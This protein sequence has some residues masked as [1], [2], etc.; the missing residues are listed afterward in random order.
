MSDTGKFNNDMASSQMFSQSEGNIVFSSDQDY[1]ILLKSI[2]FQ[3]PCGLV[4][5]NCRQNTFMAND[6]FYKMFNVSLDSSS[7]YN[8]APFH[9]EF[10]KN[11]VADFDSFYNH[12]TR[13]IEKGERV[14]G[15]KTALDSGGT[16]T[17]DIT[18]LTNKHNLCFARIWQYTIAESNASEGNNEL[19]NN[20]YFKALFNNSTDAI[21]FFNSDYKI[22][23]I[24]KNFELLF[25]HTLEKVKGLDVD[26]AMEIGKPG[27]ANYSYTKRVLA[28][29]TVLSEGTRYRKNGEAIEVS[30]KGVPVKTDSGELIGGYAIY[31]DI[32]DQVEAAKTLKYK[33]EFESM[34]TDISS[35]FVNAQPDNFDNTVDYALQKSG[36]FFQVDRSYMFLIS[37][38]RT[39][40]NNTHEWC[41]NGIKPQIHI[42]QNININNF[43][44]LQKKI[45]K[46]WYLSIYDIDTLPPEASLEKEAFKKQDI[47]SLLLVPFIIDDLP[48]GFFGY[49]TVKDNRD[50]TEEQISLLKI[51]AEVI[52]SAYSKNQAEEIIQ[53]RDRQ[54]DSL[55]NNIPGMIYRCKNDSHWTMKYVSNFCQQLTGYKPDDLIENKVI[56]Y[57]ELVLPKFREDL[58][59]KWQDK[60]NKNEMYEGEYQINTSSG[61]IKWVMERGVGIFDENNELL[62]LEGY[63]TDVTNRKMAEEAL[64]QSEE[65]FRDILSSIEEGY[66][67]TNLNGVI[68]YC[69]EAACK[70]LGY[71]IEEFIGLSYQT[72]CKDPDAM[73]SSFKQLYETGYF[74]QPLVAEMIKNDSSESYVEISL[75]LIKDKNNNI[76]GFRGIGRDFT[77]RKYF[78]DQLKYLSLHDQLTGLYNRFF[79]ENAIKRLDK[80]REHPI[81]VIS[82]DLDGLKLVNDTVG[83]DRG[84]KL[85]IGCATVLKQALRNADILARVGGDEF[86]ALLPRTD[87]KTGEM[88]IERIQEKVNEYNDQQG[89]EIPLSISIG[90][91]T[92]ESHDQLIEFTFREADDLMYREK[93]HKG[94]DAR[95]QILQSLMAALGERDYITTGHALRLEK[96]CLKIAEEISLTKKQISNLILLSQVHDLGK[97]GIPDNIL[98]KEIALTISEWEVMN[99]HSEKGYRIALASTDLSDI[100][101][102]ILKHHERWDGNGY[103]LGL[104]REEIPIECR[105]LAIADA[106]DAMTNDRPYRKAMDSKKAIDEIKKNAGTQFD[107]KLADIFILLYKNGAI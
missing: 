11:M 13:A 16:L 27:S 5:E 98:Y 1:L 34:V 100:A 51:V 25:G 40:L 86:V 41:A 43:N 49:D 73:Y 23:D 7:N 30:I 54:L 78:E 70:I 42:N 59:K 68:T 56:S 28:G 92:S 2:L 76:T 64:K 90:I 32:T 48:A 101:D 60:L 80:S 26:K 85:L 6:C 65:R 45:N 106:Y 83:H 84:D 71:T 18:P 19:I 33:L 50:W 66:F 62:F 38:D 55:L 94:V 3:S 95:S 88:I 67:E 69:N 35:R 22:I 8:K 102:L 63:I 75:S 77:E 91:S 74:K 57:N 36:E 107:P 72:F 4:I 15:I 9:L 61:E 10:I 20:R 53:E 79:F 47:K 104:K 103:P 52:S 105:I 46:S 81:S 14:A 82:I 87:S 99:Q 29:K 89:N 37:K 96:L 21:A 39:I 17:L 12:V 24:N 44:W 97:V 31:S 93:L 58:R